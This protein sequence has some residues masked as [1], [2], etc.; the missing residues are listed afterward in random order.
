[1]EWKSTDLAATRRIGYF[2]RGRRFWRS[3]I[4]GISNADR[5]VYQSFRLREYLEAGELFQFAAF[6]ATGGD[7]SLFIDFFGLSNVRGTLLYAGELP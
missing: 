7:L 2:A 5:R 1:M 3:S 4:Q 6:Q